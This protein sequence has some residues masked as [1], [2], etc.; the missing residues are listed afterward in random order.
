[1]DSQLQSVLGLIGLRFRVRHF[2]THCSANS[3]KV[4]VDLGRYARPLMARARLSSLAQQALLVGN[5]ARVPRNLCTRFRRLSPCSITSSQ[6]L[7]D[8]RFLSRSNCPFWNRRR[9][10]FPPPCPVTARS[11]SVPGSSFSTVEIFPSIRGAR[12]DGAGRPLCGRPSR[13]SNGSELA[14]PDDIAFRID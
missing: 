7:T 4:V 5:S 13:P 12:S 9:A 10:K 14:E 11:G 1:M 8:H 2:S 3:R 6:D